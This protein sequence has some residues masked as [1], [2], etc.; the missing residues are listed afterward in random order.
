M[1]ARKIL[2]VLLI[3]MLPIILGSISPSE[4]EISA[5]FGAFSYEV[6]GDEITITKYDKTDDSMEVEI[7]STIKGKPVT[8]IGEKAF[9]GCEYINKITIP[10]SV[11][12][13]GDE[14]FGECD[15]L[16][17]I[18][19][20]DSVISI[21]ERAFVYCKSLEE[22]NLPNRIKSIGIKTFYNCSS[23]EYIK[24]P[25]SVTSIAQEA[26]LKCEAM[27]NITL[28]S[29]IEK[30]EFGTFS[31]CI[32]LESIV[33][34]NGVKSIGGSAFIFCGSLESITLPRGLT[35]IETSAFKNCNKLSKIYG[36]DGSYAQEYASANNIPFSIVYDVHFDTQDDNEN[37]SIIIAH[38]NKIIKPQDPI[39][40]GY[41]FGGWFKDETLEN[42]WDFQN[43]T[44]IEDTTLYAKWTKTH[45]TAPLAQLLKETNKDSSSTSMRFI[46][47]IESLDFLE[48]G[49][50]I[51]YSNSDPF[52]DQ[53]ECTT[54]STSIAY[55]RIKAA[56]DF[57]TS[58]DLGGEGYIVAV[59]LDDIENK[60]FSKDI[61]VKPYVKSLDG[62]IHYGNMSVF[63]VEQCLGY[64][65]YK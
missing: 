42:T 24:I 27:T 23:L 40:T 48:A 55:K 37:S 44:I 43:D 64:I 38:D 61:Y 36:Y 47:T 50:V 32:L 45:I 65:D 25:D 8:K 54:K 35:N 58:D 26:F 33:I 6:N 31:N 59:I 21:G 60:S 56:G 4:I 34:P 1:K 30:I 63:S 28:P 17:S 3:L 20:P 53:D 41:A 19:I 15:N 51:S 7:P 12:S 5:E 18:E 14:A 52:I 13:I 16:K 29:S 46:S 62:T 9:Y 22:I 49:F 10:E 2:G 39:R 11:T 57:I